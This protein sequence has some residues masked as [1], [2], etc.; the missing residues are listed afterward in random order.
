MNRD[1]FEIES[2]K[3]EQEFKN[4]K[5]KLIREFCDA[6]N[7][8]RVGDK[9]TDHVGS[10]IIEKIRYSIDS[11][12]MPSCVYSGVELKKDGSRKKNDPKRSACQFNDINK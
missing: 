9:F 5:E 2:I 1:Q 10:I 6:N 8:Y 11:T 3:I 7:P 4:K 12:G